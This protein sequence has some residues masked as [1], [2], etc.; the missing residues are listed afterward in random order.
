MRTAV[1]LEWNSIADALPG[2]EQY[3]AGRLGQ[4]GRD[5]QNITRPLPRPSAETAKG[6][7][8]NLDILHHGALIEGQCWGQIEHVLV[9]IPLTC[10]SQTM[11]YGVVPVMTSRNARRKGSTHTFERSKREKRASNIMVEVTQEIRFG[12]AY[13][14]I[15]TKH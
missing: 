3:G 13:S 8:N 6:T 14:L 2:P 12:N 9:Q 4:V 5:A 11:L 10:L 7:W 1:F 15:S